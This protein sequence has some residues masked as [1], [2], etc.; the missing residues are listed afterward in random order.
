MF[1][2]HVLLW[3]ETQVNDR[4]EEAPGRDQ[5]QDRGPGLL[6]HARRRARD[7]S[8]SRGTRPAS[9]SRCTCARARAWT[10]ASTSSSPRPTTSTTASNA[11]KG[12]QQHAARRLGLLH[13]QVPRHR[14]R[15][16]GVAARAR[17]RVPGRRWTTASRS[18]WRPAAW[19]FKDP[20]VKLEAVTMG[21]KTGLF[22]GGGKLTWNRFTGPGPPGH[23]DDVHRAAR[24]ARVGR[25]AA[26]PRGG[27]A[28]ALIARA[29][30]RG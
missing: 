2:H 17:Q 21:L 9:A 4:A 27:I 14:R 18:T 19:L 20:S 12:V 6:R 28:G 29:R 5:A 7:G 1:E 10:C 24:G 3:K 26:R 11:I 25:G 15:R 23:P 8:P 13:G 30:R 16:A 22:G